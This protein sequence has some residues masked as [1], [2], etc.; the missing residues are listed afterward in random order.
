MQQ[1]SRLSPHSAVL[2]PQPSVGRADG[3]EGFRIRR[4]LRQD[5]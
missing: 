3:V 4:I 2:R 1:S 5:A